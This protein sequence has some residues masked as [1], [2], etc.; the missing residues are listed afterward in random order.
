M[1]AACTRHSL[2]PPLEEGDASKRN[3]GGFPSREHD[4]LRRLDVLRRF[5]LFDI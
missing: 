3:S 4:V 5:G 2:R 1:G